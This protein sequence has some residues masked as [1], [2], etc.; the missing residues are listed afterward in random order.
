VIGALA[1]AE[2]LP[3]YSYF[4]ARF[5]VMVQDIAQKVTAY[6][7]FGALLVMSSRR[8]QARPWTQRTCIVAV[9]AAA[10]AA[11][12]EGGQL[13]LLIRT[14]SLTDLLIAL[15]AGGTGAALHEHAVKFYEYARS[16]AAV[17]GRAHPTEAELSLTDQLIATLTEP[18][19]KAP[20]E[21]LPERRPASQPPRR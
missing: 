5:D 3:L 16:R 6:L 19:P 1:S 13:F 21:T 2:M 20:E 17:T 10:L 7:L 15:L 18:H 11:T 9:L 8:L 14:T 4:H 12:L